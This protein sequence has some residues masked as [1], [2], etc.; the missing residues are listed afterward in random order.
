L[1]TEWINNDAE[2]EAIMAKQDCYGDFSRFMSWKTKDQMR[3]QKL[4]P[5]LFLIDWSFG[6]F[7]FVLKKKLAQTPQY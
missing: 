3:N 5:I 4:I 2:N 7:G 1:G 6:I